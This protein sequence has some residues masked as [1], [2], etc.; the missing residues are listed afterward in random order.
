MSQGYHSA[1][2]HRR[3]ERAGF[4]LETTP[5]GKRRWRTP[6]TGKLVSEERAVEAARWEPENVEGET[7]WLRPDS[8]CLYPREA[9]YDILER[10]YEEE[11]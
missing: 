10:T 8:G 3:L 2:P 4:R 7:Y 9:A 5:A 11:R 1:Q 6:E